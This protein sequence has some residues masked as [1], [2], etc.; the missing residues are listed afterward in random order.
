MM[1]KSGLGCVVPKV[2]VVAY[3]GHM[4]VAKF[5]SL[6]PLKCGAIIA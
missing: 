2:A 3:E 4:F 1:L 6:S 5:V